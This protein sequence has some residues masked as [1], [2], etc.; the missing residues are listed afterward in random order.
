MGTCPIW[1]MYSRKELVLSIFF[2]YYFYNFAVNLYSSDCISY[3][4]S[5]LVY[6]REGFSPLFNLDVLRLKN[7]LTF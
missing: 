4:L 6:L 5:P 1:E 3:N 7:N 2:S